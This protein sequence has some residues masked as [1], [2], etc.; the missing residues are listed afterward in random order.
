MRLGCLNHALLTAQSIEQSG[1]CSL[2]GWVG[3]VIEPTFPRLEGNLDTLRQRLTFPCLG[4]IPH[5]DVVSTNSAADLLD[6][7]TLNPRQ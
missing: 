7:S 6:I 3:N 1:G 4:V 5:L 2:V